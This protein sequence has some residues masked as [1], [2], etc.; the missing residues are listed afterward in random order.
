MDVTTLLSVHLLTSFDNAVGTWYSA[1]LYGVAFN[2]CWQTKNKQGRKLTFSQFLLLIPAT[3]KGLVCASAHST[4]PEEGTAW[5]ASEL[6]V[7]LVD[8]FLQNKVL[9]TNVRPR[10]QESWE[11]VKDSCGGDSVER[12]IETPWGWSRGTCSI[13]VN[14]IHFFLFP[15][16]WDLLFSYNWVDAP[17]VPPDWISLS[18]L[19]LPAQREG[20]ALDHCCATGLRYLGYPLE[21]LVSFLIGNFERIR[22]RS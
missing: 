2:Y 20:I 10:A 14:E 18:V 17:V 22:F 19:M 6:G 11:P 13:L 3:V 21:A 9:F 12:G 16:V 1:F 5:V 4:S 15:G 8:V 7:S